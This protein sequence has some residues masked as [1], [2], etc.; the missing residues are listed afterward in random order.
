MDVTMATKY[1]T[2]NDM[3]CSSLM[4]LSD[5]EA[6]WEESG[7]VAVGRFAWLKKAMHW[8]GLSLSSEH[9]VE[10]YV[11]NVSFCSGEF[12][13]FEYDSEALRDN[14]KAGLLNAIQ[15]SDKDF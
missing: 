2:L 4:N 11:L 15:Q 5:I 10:M 1:V 13:C 3:E 14:D 8:I 12:Y 9:Y 7:I 6:V